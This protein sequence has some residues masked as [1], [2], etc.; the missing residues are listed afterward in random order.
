MQSSAGVKHKIHGNGY[1]GEKT[2][3]KSPLA[4]ITVGGVEVGHH[5][6]DTINRRSDK[7]PVCN[8]SAARDCTRTVPGN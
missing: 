2:A 6:S 1:D 7:R 8:S 4:F 5:D 3:V